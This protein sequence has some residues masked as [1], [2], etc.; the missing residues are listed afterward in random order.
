MK[1]EGWASGACVLEPAQELGCQDKSVGIEE[2]GVVRFAVD[3]V[4]KLVFERG[5]PTSNSPGAANYRRFSS[6]YCS[7]SM[8]RSKSSSAEYP[9]K[10]RITSSLAN[11]RQM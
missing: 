10:L 7:S 3:M 4:V 1:R 11:S 8:I 9:G 5:P 6:V 2:C